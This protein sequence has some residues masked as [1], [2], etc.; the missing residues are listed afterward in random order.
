MTVNLK[1]AYESAPETEDIVI[2]ESEIMTFTTNFCYLGSVIDFLIGDTTD[3]KSRVNK[4][5]KAMGALG[6]IWKA[7]QTCLDTKIKLFLAIPVNL[8]LWNCETWSGN[9]MDMDILDVFFHKSIRRILGINMTEVKEKSISNIKLRKRFG[10]VNSLSHIMTCRMLKFVG[11]T[12]RQDPRM[13]SRRML[14]SFTPGKLIRGRPFRTNRDAIVE[15]IRALIPST[16][17]SAPTKYWYGYAYDVMTW[18]K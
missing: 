7:P 9:K 18:E 15:A 13:L 6:F 4:A 8:A 10:N 5:I 2:N 16:P 12:V 3:V 14:T 1:E 11:R 17:E